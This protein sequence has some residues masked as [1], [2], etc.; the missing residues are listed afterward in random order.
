MHHGMR[1]GL[2]KLCT[3]SGFI[4]I[5]RFDAFFRFGVF[6]KNKTQHKKF[7]QF[8]ELINS[9][10]TACHRTFTEVKYNIHSKLNTK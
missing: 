8:F 6:F 2:C 9:C 3:V 5:F 4:C 7:R 10:A 1:Y